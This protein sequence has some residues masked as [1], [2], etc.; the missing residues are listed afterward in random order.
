MRICARNTLCV[1]GHLF[2]GDGGSTAMTLNYIPKRV[3][4]QDDLNAAAIKQGAHA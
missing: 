4:H 2:K 1:V 3:A